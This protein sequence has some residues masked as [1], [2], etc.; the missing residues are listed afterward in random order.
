MR[1]WTVRNQ[2]MYNTDLRGSKDHLSVQLGQ[3]AQEQFT[4]N[5]VTVVR[6]YNP[7]LNNYT[8]LNYA[9]LSNGIFG[10]V[11][12]GRSVF[13]EQP[14]VYSETLTRGTSYFALLNYSINQKYYFDAS[15]RADHSNVF[16]DDVSGQKKP[17]YSLGAK[18]QISQEN[19]MK[20]V[21]WIKGLGLRATYGI[22]GNSP[23]IG[24]GSPFDVLR[25]ETN[26]T[27]GNALGVQSV[28][29]SKLSWESTHTY[30]LGIDF[31]LLQYRLTGG[32]DAYHKNTTDLLSQIPLNPLTGSTTIRGNLGDIRNDGIELSLHSINLR[33]ADFTWSSNFVFSH[34]T[35]K[36]VDYTSSI[37]LSTTLQ[38]TYRISAQYVPGYS[39]FSLFAYRF[40]GLD[41]LGDPQ[42]KLANGTVT[43]TPATYSA[44][45][46][47]YMGSTIP[48]M[49]GGFSNT[50]R[51]KSVSIAANMIY[52]LGAV[53]R[54][55][56]NTFYSGRLASSTGFGGNINSDFANRWKVPGDEAKT[57]IPSYVAGFTSRRNLSYYTL[58]DINVVS[59]SYVKLR[60]VT[61]SYNF[62][63]KLL[64][65]L[66]LESLS[67]FAQGGNV[68]IW[69]ANKY[70][71]DPEYGRGLP[72]GHNYAFGI[73]ASF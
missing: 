40:A 16:G 24:A 50:F 25:V 10:A 3:E 28:A 7:T 54:R 20:D 57:D 58:A 39:A 33:S 14:Y 34:N 37:P 71:I 52:S 22:T 19:F 8:L 60:D 53:M 11:S 48:T 35:N 43:K 44:N 70:D 26:T 69:T 61:L 32:I 27:T 12:T 42:I 6:G 1:N 45:D 68:L 65:T 47:V 5:N 72:P 15:I 23:Y 66:K 41:N 4:S 67:V 55:D 31:S 49:N 63:R 17:A 46:L 73:N 29:N 62:S 38:D 36:L 13:S 2:L 30:N 51:Y 59:A 9:A 21:N 64:Q 56:V 18:W